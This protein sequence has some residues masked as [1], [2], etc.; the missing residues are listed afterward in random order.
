MPGQHALKCWMPRLRVWSRGIVE[1]L[2]WRQVVETLEAGSIVVVDEAIEEGVAVGVGDEEPVGDTAFG[3]PTDRF[4][5]PAI[6][7]FDEAI[8]LRPVRPCEAV[9]DLALGAN[10]IE[11]V[12]AGRPI[13]GFVLHV[14]GEPISELT[15]IVGEDGMNTM[16]EVSEEAIE[17]ACRSVSIAPGM[18]LQIDVAGSPVDGD[19]GIAFASF[20]GRQVFEID[21]NEAD[22]CLFEDTDRW[23]VGFGPSAQPMTLETTVG[24]TAGDF[25]IDAAPHHFG[26][27]IERQLQAGSQLAD[28]RF[29]EQRE[30]GRQPLR[31]VRAIS[32]RRAPTPTVNCGLAHPQFVRKL[33]NWP[34]AALNVAADF[35]RGRGVSVQAQLHDARR[36]RIYEMPWSTPIPSN[37]SSGTKHESGDPGAK[38][39]GCPLSR[40]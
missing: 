32:D 5:D 17:E 10:A 22:S 19:K 26:D 34:L 13:A 21:V 27:V 4:D 9:I 14:D 23:L 7:A 38:T 18:D 31:R 29:F 15:A 28:K 1:H 39:T 8:G 36:S 35:G 25:S 3:L 24:G 40:A 30:L 33:R 6:E 16:R 20:Q 2:A 12:P 11:G 37:Q